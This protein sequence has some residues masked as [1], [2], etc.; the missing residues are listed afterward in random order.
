MHAQPADTSSSSQPIAREEVTRADLQA[1]VARLARN[2]QERIVLIDNIVCGV[3]P[4]AI[5]ERHPDLFADIRAVY[6]AKRDVLVRFRHHCGL[7][8]ESQPA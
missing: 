5:L 4:R 3:P 2:E 7:Q 6:A 8:Q 1:S